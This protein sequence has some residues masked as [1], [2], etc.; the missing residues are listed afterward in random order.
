ML[1]CILYLQET[2][3][4][5]KR[6]TLHKAHLNSTEVSTAHKYG[7]TKIISSCKHYDIVPL[8]GVISSVCVCVFMSVCEHQR[9]CAVFTP[10]PRQEINWLLI[11]GHPGEKEMT[12][13]LKMCQMLQAAGFRN[14]SEWYEATAR[15]ASL[16]SSPFSVSLGTLFFSFSVCR[17][18]CF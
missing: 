11:S 9:V 3:V 7:L 4:T 8:A 15:F 1:A 13:L 6:K 5:L 14:K 10:H 16:P 2:T 17:G 12:V 18:V